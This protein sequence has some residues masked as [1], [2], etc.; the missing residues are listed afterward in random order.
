MATSMQPTSLEPVE[1]FFRGQF[2]KPGDKVVTFTQ[3]GRGTR[4]MR[5]TFVGSMRVEGARHSWTYFLVDRAD[6]TRT[7]LTYNGMV[8]DGTTLGDLD[9]CVLS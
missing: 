6:G 2:I 7:K 4:V 5:G 1:G 3:A 8:P 9:G